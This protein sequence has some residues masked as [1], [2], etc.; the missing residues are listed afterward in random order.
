MRNVLMVLW[1]VVCLLTGCSK[2]PAD[3]NST[4]ALNLSDNTKTVAWNAGSVSVTMIARSEWT[5]SED[6]DWVHP[7]MT[8]GAA[9]SSTQ[10]VTFRL[11]D[12]T[13]DF[14]RRAAVSFSASGES[15]PYTFTIVQ[16]PKNMLS[17][18]NEWIHSELAD[19]YYW[20]EVVKITT[21]PSNSLAPND[22]FDQTLLS[23]PWAKVQDHT[24]NP[25][26]IDGTWGP[27]Y[28]TEDGSVRN[29]Y[30]FIEYTGGTRADDREV[31]FGFRVRT[32]YINSAGTQYALLVIWVQENSPAWNAGLRRG[33]WI[34]GFNNQAINKTVF[35][36][37]N[38]VF[39]NQSGP[40][41]ITLTSGR[42][43][44]FRAA[45]TSREPISD[46]HSKI[47]TSPGG[48]RVA[49]LYYNEF[50][51]GVKENYDY[52]FHNS[53]R[54]KFAEFRQGAATELVLDLRYNSGGY[55][56]TCQLLSSL[57]SGANKSQ[58]FAKML[59]SN[60][61]PDAAK[62]GNPQ[63]LSFVN[64]PNSLSLPARRIYVLTSEI[65]ASASEM[66][67][68]SLRGIDFEVVTIGTR[69][70][71]KNVGMDQFLGSGE[72]AG[73][74]MLPITFKCLNAKN[75]A[76]FAGGFEPNYYKDE[77][78]DARNTAEFFDFGNPK[79]LLFKAALTLI[80]GG[81]VT[82]DPQTRTPDH[83]A[84]VLGKPRMVGAKYIP[85]Q[86]R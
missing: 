67:I 55:I 16:N 60:T 75:D 66:L 38:S 76:N 82:S 36:Q 32:F 15:A 79:E 27:Q 26:T 13:S 21:A 31:T 14:Q 80:D 23:L 47:I 85:E 24:E 25:A 40:M 63:E 8:S 77:F 73:W 43:M 58:I 64:E 19:H 7:A 9:S 34:V 33:D 61:N 51:W 18:V 28:N 4:R 5:L 42:R 44:N 54:Q 69:T 37:L 68:S 56:T 17:G 35:E 39:V 83:Q 81:T 86:K 30:S 22:F 1:G 3:K 45:E 71:G 59:R 84:P 6:A 65:T 78:F 12:N 29:T 46:Y 11:D 62:Y 50:E 72:S 41:D 74:V 57:V 2:T 48:R 52:S 53:M 70:N 49:Y 10:T 20:N